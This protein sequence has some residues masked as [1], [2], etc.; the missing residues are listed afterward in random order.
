MKLYPEIIV[1][2]SIAGSEASRLSIC[3]NTCS[4][5]SCD[6]PGGRSTTAIMVPVSSFGTSPVGVIFIKKSNKAM[7]ATTDP[8]V[9]QGLW[10]KF[11]VPFLYFFNIP[12]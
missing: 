2:L 6:V 12:S 9:S 3:I 5:R 1:R 8:I 4:V 7:P 11:S 10:M